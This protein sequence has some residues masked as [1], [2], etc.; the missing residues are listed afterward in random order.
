MNLRFFDSEKRLKEE[1]HAFMAYRHP[2]G[3]VSREMPLI[4][5]LSVLENIAL[6][7]QYHSRLSR[8]RAEEMAREYLRRPQLEDLV[9]RL[10]PTLR[11]EQ[12][13]CV[14]VLRAVMLEDSILVL[15]RPFEMMPALGDRKSVQAIHASL[16][17]TRQITDQV[18]ILLKK[19]D[20][21]IYGKDGILPLVTK[22][23]RELA[24]NLA[25]IGATLDNITKIT[26]DSAGS[27]K[28]LKL[29]RSDIDATVNSLNRLLDELNRK[30]PF[31]SEPKIKLP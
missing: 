5:N 10:N 25:K 8:R 22:A 13:F 29:L 24:N 30:M 17:N 3:L 20:E 9:G 11:E 4:S 28:D 21:D 16:R 14:M 18:N 12:R 31:K 15:D 23:L 19:T 2:V 6:I 7:R 1:L 26:S 27:T